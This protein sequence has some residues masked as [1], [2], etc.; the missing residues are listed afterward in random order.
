MRKVSHIHFVGIGGIGM[1]GIAEVLLH[2]GY[3]ISGSD[4]AKNAI[5]ERLISLGAQIYYGHDVK[6]VLGADVVVV[7][8]AVGSEN[9]EVVAA[10]KL[11]IPIIPRAEML[12]ELMRFRFGIV[13]SG[14][15][16]KTT[17]TSLMASVL[18]EGG[19]DPTF[20][21]GGR[22]NSA[23]TNAKLGL[24]Q[25]LVAEADESD[26]SFLCLQPTI[27]VVTNIDEDHMDT[28]H[29]DIGEL[30]R[31]FQ[32]F[33]QRLPFYGLGVLCFDDPGVRAILP[34]VS[35]PYITYGFDER[36]DISAF[37]FFQ[38]G[39]STYF[40]VRRTGRSDNLS[41]HLNLAGKH[42][43]LNALAV[44][45]VSGELGISDQMICRAFERFSGVGRRFQQIGR[46]KLTQG[47]ALFID[48]YGHH[49][50]EVA[51][52]ISTARDGWPGRRLVMIFQPHRYT[53]TRDLF[54]DFVKVLVG[55]DVLVLLDVY[56]ACEPPIE[57]ADSEH[58]CQ[59]VAEKIG[60]QPILVHEKDKLPQILREV[61]KDGDIV[62]TQG[63]G[64]V[65]MIAKELIDQYGFQKTED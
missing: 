62:L 43:V 26:A 42:N 65:S 45:G 15:H 5:T 9:V 54:H 51:A 28:Y 13:V 33:L 10:K 53:R 61:L 44:I 38:S 35:R 49:P 58:L 16:G 30:R 7:S 18:A 8:S 32:A 63:A 6:S 34:F 59:S 29:H 39:T 57:G 41:V 11:S 24:G 23:K 4:L 17:T 25:Y 46:F 40:D 20:V 64:N 2:E 37:N 31:A 55:V 52:T 56:P 12:A 14:T 48:D 27:A 21:I 50:K 47:D 36:A 60:V 22:L 1:S 19:L 3:E